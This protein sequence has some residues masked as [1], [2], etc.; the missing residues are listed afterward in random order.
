MR[1]PVG[2]GAAPLRG[3]VTA[4]GV[5]HVRLLSG[6]R[7]IAI[8]APGRVMVCTANTGTMLPMAGHTPVSD[9]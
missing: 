5:G 4:A 7:A 9:R 1:G 3:L 8:G 2:S 6:I